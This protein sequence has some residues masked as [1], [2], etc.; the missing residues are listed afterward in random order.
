MN[1]RKMALKSKR[2]SGGFYYSPL[3]KVKGHLE[4]YEVEDRQGAFA[5]A[6]QQDVTL[7]LTNIE[8]MEADSPYPYKTAEIKLKFSDRLS[9]AYVIFEDSIDAVLGKETGASSVDDLVGRDLVLEREDNHIFFTDT[10]TNKT[11]SGT[12]WRVMA[13][14]G[15][16]SAVSPLET[17]LKLLDGLTAEQFK[18]EAIKN[19]SVKRDVALINSII[20][21]KF[22]KSD[23]V[24]TLFTIV[25][26]KFTKKA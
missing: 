4:R 9:S 15:S 10:K 21:D 11:N 5:K 17:A 26:G 12:V 6:G 1:G 16:S 8:V 20:S 18:S 19:P 25:D 22:F 14:E 7:F 13:V 23:G 2:L 24:S 3:K